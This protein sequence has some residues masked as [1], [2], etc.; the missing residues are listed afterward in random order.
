M[1]LALIPRLTLLP[2]PALGLG[3]AADR[4]GPS[5]GEPAGPPG[6]GRRAPARA[7]PRGRPP[8]TGS[9][10]SERRPPG[11]RRRHGITDTRATDDAR[12][13]R[14]MNRMFRMTSRASSST[15][16]STGLTNPE[17]KPPREA[18]RNG[19]S[20]TRRLGDPRAARVQVDG[21]GTPTG[22]DGQQVAACPGI[23]ADRGPLVD[24]AAAPPPL[25]GARQPVR[26]G[27]RRL[28][29]SARRRL[30]SPPMSD[31]A[32]EDRPPG[33]IDDLDSPR[34]RRAPLPLGLLLPRWGIDARRAG[35]RGRRARPRGA[36]PDRPR[37]RLG[38][39]GVR[40]RRP[41]TRPP[42]DPR[43]RADARRRPPR[44][45][46]GRLGSRLDQPLPSPDDRPCPHPRSGDPA[47]R[48]SST[49]PIGSGRASK[50]S[51]TTP[52]ASS[53]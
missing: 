46:A 21:E 4:L 39:D 3:L 49:G 30:V 5:T 6:G 44:H 13:V 40:P 11:R 22:I 37:R 52:T 24:R 23:L 8:G 1:R 45:P 2:A 48:A 10:R 50:S 12:A 15:D 19:P 26:A 9:R 20:G 42:A 35:R 18:A 17:A 32:R 14:V 31:R 29:R 51:A 34:V 7:P 43:G 38:I 16:P 41:R 28:P 36:G 53:A 47:T 25:L 33:G 27:H